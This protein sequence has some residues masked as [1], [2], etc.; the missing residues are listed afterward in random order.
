MY[1]L[2]I[3]ITVVFNKVKQPELTNR[4]GVYSH[5]DFSS[6]IKDKQFWNKSS[7][8]IPFI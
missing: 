2:I 1:L 4:N 3:S 5:R 8:K 7:F 6:S